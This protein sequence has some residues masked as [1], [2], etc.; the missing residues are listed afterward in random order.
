MYKE[1]LITDILKYNL[2]NWTEEKLNKMAIR[3]LERILFY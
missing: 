3:S 2:G 1:N